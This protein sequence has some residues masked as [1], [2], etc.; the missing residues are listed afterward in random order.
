MDM[1]ETHI[2]KRPNVNEGLE[3]LLSLVNEADDNLKV[4][5]QKLFENGSVEECKHELK[6]PADCIASKIEQATGKIESIT[7]LLSSIR[8]KL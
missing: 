5:H 8:N 4:I 3:K 2:T 1:N 6:Q 7:K